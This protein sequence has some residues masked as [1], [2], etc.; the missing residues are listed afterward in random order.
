MKEQLLSA[1]KAKFQGVNANIL[2]RIASMLAKTVTTEDQVKTSVEGVTQELIN[3]ID[4]YGDSRA[5]EATKTAVQNYEQK[6]GLKDGAKVE[7]QKKAEKT[8]DADDDNTPAWA[9]ALIASNA[10]LTKRLNDMEGERTTATRR[11]ELEGIISKL[12]ENQRKGYAR[13]SVDAMSDDEFN[14]LKDEVAG[15][16]ETLVKEAGAKKSIFGRPAG[17]GGK[18]G[19]SGDTQEASEAEATAVVDRLNL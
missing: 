8:K 3:V 15:E 16:V 14:T 17:G 7:Q 4:A 2:D 5:T 18:M 12:P 10:E 1:L 11:K 6:Y 9:K 19:G 13:I